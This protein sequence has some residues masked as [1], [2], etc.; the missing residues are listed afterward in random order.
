MLEKY[1]NASKI[2]L[3]T[4]VIKKYLVII[5]ILLYNANI[6]RINYCFIK[7]INYKFYNDEI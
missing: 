6:F 1:K 4:L 7:T 5:F 2:R 3:N